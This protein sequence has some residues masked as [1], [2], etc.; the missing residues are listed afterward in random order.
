MKRY[1]FFRDL[2]LVLQLQIWALPS[3]Q[4]NQSVLKMFPTSLSK[5][6]STS[7]QDI[8]CLNCF[9]WPRGPVPTK[10]LCI[11]PNVVK[12]TQ[13]L[14]PYIFDHIYLTPWNFHVSSP[15]IPIVPALSTKVETVGKPYCSSLRSM[16]SHSSLHSPAPTTDTCLSD[17]SETN[18][19]GA[20][21]NVFSRC[22]SEKLAN[23]L[24]YC[25]GFPISKM[26]IDLRLVLAFRK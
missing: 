9:F 26:F 16:R 23:P 21:G 24:T 4:Q 5:W 20:P 14:T 7:L 1:H 11:R 2:L 3:L 12:N 22:L 17:Q 8:M 19:Y 18:L 6:L 25:E 13:F 10:H 15:P